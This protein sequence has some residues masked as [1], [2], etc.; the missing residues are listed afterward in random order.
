MQP[1]YE[2]LS[3]GYSW[4]F[5]QSWLVEALQAI[6]SDKTHVQTVKHG[7]SVDATIYQNGGATMV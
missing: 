5:G 6:S 3:V 1:E 7:I 2:I 4:K